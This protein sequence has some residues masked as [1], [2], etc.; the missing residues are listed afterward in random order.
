MKNLPLLRN[1]L[2]AALVAVSLASAA[3]G[4]PWTATGPD[5]GLVYALAADPTN[6]AVG[7]AATSGGLFATRDGGATWSRFGLLPPAYSIAVDDSGSK[8][9]VG[10]VS[11]AWSTVDRGATWRQALPGTQI[12][13]VAFDPGRPS[14]VYAS[15]YGPSTL[16]LYRSDDGAATFAQVRAS[17]LY[18]SYSSIVVSRSNPRTAYFGTSDGIFRTDD[19]GASLAVVDGFDA[20]LGR[21]ISYRSYFVAVD[22]ERPTRIYGFRTTAT[23]GHLC[24]SG[25]E[26][27]HWS[28]CGGNLHQSILALSVQESAAGRKSLFATT[29]G[30]VFRSDDEGQSWS[31]AGLGL[32]GSPYASV[33][34]AGSGAILVGT[35]SG[36]FR[37][38]DAGG[39]WSS[40]SN[41]LQASFTGAL[42][43]SHADSPALFAGTDLGLF[44][45]DGAGWESLLTPGVTSFASSTADPAIAFAGSQGAILKTIDGGDH[46]SRLISNLGSASA[47]AIDPVTPANVYAGELQYDYRDGRMGGIFKTADSG[48]SWEELDIH[49]PVYTLL[50][51]SL[52]PKTIYAGSDFDLGYYGG[53]GGL[54]KSDDGGQ[55]WNKNPKN[56]GGSVVALALDPKDS[57]TLYLG[58]AQGFG[59]NAGPRPLFKSTDRGETWTA[60][61]GGAVVYGI[62][63]I[64]V[65]PLFDG[66][67]YVATPT[68]VFRTL[69]GGRAWAELASGLPPSLPV[70]QLVLE[71]SRRVLHAGTAGGGVFDLRLGDIGPCAADA[72][73]LCLLGG[74]F[75]VTLSATD[76]RRSRSSTGTA[77]GQGD[78][79]G[80]FSLPDFTG[81]ASLPEIVVKMV[82]ASQ[83]GRSFWFFYS[84]LTSLPY[85]VTVRDTTTGDLKSYESDGYCGG[86]DT[87]AFAGGGP[88]GAQELATDGALAASGAELLLLDGRFRVTLSASNPRNGRVTEG[89]AIPQ[90]ERFGYFSLPEFTGDANFPEVFVKIIDG[91]RLPGHA[92]WVFHTGLTSLPYTLSVTDTVSGITQTYAN[93]GGGS[94]LFCGGADTKSFEAFP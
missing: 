15:V 56:F 33:Q 76:S 27:V 91:T 82:D 30:G 79:F 16:G 41:G 67:I 9:V 46:W 51:D 38:V 52:Q 50:I 2:A 58:T 65:D 10:T 93:G 44:R 5:G 71:E 57:S 89:T 45:N 69:D 3:A 22:T 25:D 66:R 92:F 78:R 80:Y 90:G 61:G 4:A 6:P 36:I 85:T 49:T 32:Q 14:T 23:G 12:G 13:V 74:R 18:Y 26:G 77:V 81:D 75:E 47:L 42:G 39:H 31:G 86:A 63:A 11:G 8:M 94:S 21:D 54:F 68:G 37:S 70:T 48:N 53:G 34:P 84:G 62:N 40:S 72:E 87:S 60:L 55:T 24:V 20:V 43:L 19:G 59:F 88:I 83:T 35:S 64:V 28:G 7:Y 1:A 29:D 73:T 17:N